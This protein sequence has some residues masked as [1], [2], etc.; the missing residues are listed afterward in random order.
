[1]FRLVLAAGCFA[2]AGCSA[3]VSAPPPRFVASDAYT[4]GAARSTSSAALVLPSPVTVSDPDS[5]SEYN[6]DWSRRDGSL[7]VGTLTGNLT[8]AYYEGE[9]VPRL[10][11]A[12]WLYLSDN[13]RRTTYFTD[14]ARWRGR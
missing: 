6:S 14:R 9:R 5:F 12:R 11:D 10:E 8:P 4:R 2:L 1:M 3:P 7:A 13:P